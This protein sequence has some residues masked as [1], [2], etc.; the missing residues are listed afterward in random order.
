MKNRFWT[1]LKV[2]WSA[3]SLTDR[4]ADVRHTAAMALGGSNTGT[5]SLKIALRHSKT[6]VRQAAVLGLG[7]CESAGALAALISALVDPEPDV[8]ACAASTLRSL[9]WKP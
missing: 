7:C 4:N 1:S 3:S 6:Q 2:R 9:G 8:R 5:A